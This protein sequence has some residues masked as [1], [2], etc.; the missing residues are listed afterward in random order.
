MKPIIVRQTVASHRARLLRSLSMGALLAGLAAPAQA[1]FLN[2]LRPGGGAA[3]ASSGVAGGAATAPTGEG[4]TLTASMISAR[5][6]SLRNAARVT[7]AVDFSARAQAAARSAAQAPQGMVPV[8]DGLNVRNGL[9]PATGVTR[10]SIAA[11]ATQAA[12][13]ANGLATW[14]GAAYPE[15]TAGS[16]GRV[17]VTI[18]Q[19][20]PTAILSWDSFNV[21]QRTSLIFDQKLGGIAQPSWV[22]VNRIVGQLNGANN[23]IRDPLAAPLPSQILGSIKADGIVVVLNQN[24][25]LFGPTSQINMRSMLASSYEIGSDRSATRNFETISDKDGASVI[26]AGGL[27]QPAPASI[28]DR[29]LSILRDGLMQALSLQRTLVRQQRILNGQPSIINGIETYTQSFSTG[30]Q[31]IG[32]ITVSAGATIETDGPGFIILAAPEVTNSG[33]LTAAEGQVALTGPISFKAS[34]GGADSETPNIRGLALTQTATV[35]VPGRINVVRNT[36][37]GLIEAPR[38]YVSLQ[39][40]AVLQDGVIAAT[41]SVSRNG[42]I[43]LEGVNVRLGSQSALVITPD[44]NGETVPQAPS[45]VAAFKTSQITIN[46][47]ASFSFPND[48]TNPIP[49]PTIAGATGTLEFAADS[50]LYAPNAAVSILGATVLVGDGAVV[51]VGGVKDLLLDASRNTIVLET[52]KRNELRD[53]PNYRESFLNG[54][55]VVLDPRRTG[56]RSDGVAWIGSPLIE[57]GSFLDQVGVTAAELMTRGGSVVLKATGTTAIGQNFSDPATVVIRPSARFDI[58]GGWVR[59]PGGTIQTSRLVNATGQLIDIAN[60]DVNESYVGL[61]S[62]IELTQQR[63]GKVD[64]FT[65]P[66]QVVF[67]EVSAFVEGRDAGAL[68]ISSNSLAMGGTIAAQ[69]FAGTVQR[70]LA[71]PGTRTASDTADTRRLQAIAAQLPAGGYLSV[72]ASPV[73]LGVIANP[74]IGGLSFEADGVPEFG[75]ATSLGIDAAGQVIAPVLGDSGVLGEALRRR[76]TIDPAMFN[77]AGLAQSRYRITGDILVPTG[78]ALMLQEGGTFSAQTAGRIDMLGSIVVPSGRIALDTAL[79]DGPLAGSFPSL[80]PLPG[81]IASAISAT[82]GSHDLVVSGT[83]STAGKWIND[84]L[85][86]R[87][88]GQAY[89]DGGSIDLRAASSLKAITGVTPF[90]FIASDPFSP[91]RSVTVANYDAVDVSGSILVNAGALLDVSSGG[92]V[93]TDGRVTLTARGGSVRL[94][95]NTQYYEQLVFRLGGER[96]IPVTGFSDNAAGDVFSPPAITARVAFAPGTIRGHGFGGGGTFD[97]TTPLLAFGS[98]DVAGG[99]RIPLDFIE[100]SGFGTVRLASSKT[101]IFQGGFADPVPGYS[102][103]AEVQTLNIKNDETLRLSQAMFPALLTSA[104]R[105]TLLALP[106]GSDLYAVVA[107]QVPADPFDRRAANF[108]LGGLTKLRVAAGGAIEGEAGARLTVGRLLQEGR[109]RLPGGEITQQT[110]YGRSVPNYSVAPG[111]QRFEVESGIRS[112]ARTGSGAPSLAD[113]LFPNADGTITAFFTTQIQDPDSLFFSVKGTNIRLATRTGAY[114]LGVLDG[115]QGLVLAPDSDTDLSGVALI[116][117]RAPIRSQADQTAIRTGRLVSGGTISNIANS[118]GA[119]SNFGS[120]EG[121]G[122]GYAY[123]ALPFEIA[124]GAKLD[125]RGVSDQFDVPSA[126]GGYL[127]VPVWSDSGRLFST[128]LAWNSDDVHAEAIVP[129]ARGAILTLTNPSL[130]QTTINASNSRVA[131]DRIEAAGFGTFEALGDFTTAGDAR[132]RLPEA[133][134]VRADPGIGP[135]VSRNPQVIRFD[136]TGDLEV[137][138]PFIAFRNDVQTRGF[139]GFFQT[140]PPGE[141]LANTVSLTADAV[142]FRGEL[143]VGSRIGAFNV[144]AHGD[145]R[146]IGVQNP[147]LTSG[148]TTLV[149]GR[150]IPST[151]IGELVAR[152]DVNFTAGQ[153]YPTTGTIYTIELVGANNT[154]T[155]GRSPGD[156]PEVPYSAGGQFSG[157][158]ANIVHGGVIRAPIG[159]ITLGASPGAPARNFFGGPTNTLALL[160]GSVTSTA[161]LDNAEVPLIIPYGETTDVTEYFFSP[162]NPNPLTAPPVAALRLGGA[163]VDAQLGSTIDTRGGGDLYAYEFVSGVFGSRDVLERINVDPYS[164]RSGLQYA[165][166]RQVYAILPSRREDALALYDPIYSRDYSGPTGVGGLYEH[167]AGRRVFLNTAPGVEAGWYTLLPAKYA[168]LPGALRLVEQSGGRALPDDV[169]STLIDGTI[170][171]TGYFGNGFGDNRESTLRAFALQTQETFSESSRIVVTRASDVFAARALRNGLTVPALPKDAGRLSFDVTGQLDIEGRL[172]TN[173]A[174]GGRGLQ[175]D[176]GGQVI[177]IVSVLSAQPRPG[178]LELTASLLTNLNAA[179]VL[180]GGTRID[181][182]DGTTSLIPSANSIGIR[183]DSSNPLLVGDAIFV[184]NGIVSNITA[185]DG[186]TITATGAA[187]TDQTG[188]FIIRGTNKFKANEFY[189]PG[190][191]LNFV[192]PD[193]GGQRNTLYE[194]IPGVIFNAQAA[195]EDLYVLNDDPQ[196][197]RG[198]LLQVTN[199]PNR[200]VRRVDVRE[201]VDTTGA[202][203]TVEAGVSLKGQTILF[204]ASSEAR[205]DIASQLDAPNLSIGAPTIAFTDIDTGTEGFIVNKGVEALLGRAQFAT[206]SA[207]QTLDFAAGDFKFND[208]RLNTA[209]LRAR[210]PGAAVTINAREL[211]LQNNGL[212]TGTCGGS[213]ALACGTGTL[214]INST[215]AR[216]GTGTVNTYGFGGGVTLSALGGIVYEGNGIFDVGDAAFAIATPFIVDRGRALPVGVAAVPPSL[217]LQTRGALSIVA[218]VGAAAAELPEGAGGAQL[219]LAAQSI[220]VDGSVLRATAG[221][222]TVRARTDIV[223]AGRAAFLTPGYAR[224]FGDADDFIDVSA[225][226]GQLGLIAETGR[227]DLGLQTLLS[228]G[229]GSGRAG[230][231]SL[232]APLGTI[233]LGQLD[234]LAPEGRAALTLD[235]AGS[236]SLTQLFGPQGQVYNGEVDIRT[237]I[238]DLALASGLTLTVDRLA[239]T[240]DGGRISIGGTIN[241]SGVNGGDI[242][243]FGAA[244]VVLED[245][246]Q[247]NAFATGYA[248]DDSRPARGGTVT[249]GTD[250]GGSIVVNRAAIIDLAARRPGNRLIGETRSDITYFTFAEGDVGGKLLVRAPLIERPGNDTLDVRVDSAASVRGASEVSIEAFKRFDLDAIARDP[251]FTGVSRD[252]A[253]TIV[254]DTRTGLNTATGSYASTGAVNFLGGVDAAGRGLSGTLPEFVQTFDVSGAFATLGGLDALD[255][256]SAKPGVELVAAGAVTL[257][258]N[259]NLGAGTVDTAQALASGAM[260]NSALLPIVGSLLVPGKT[261]YVVPGREGEITQ[262]YTRFAY[263]TRDGSPFG[264]AGVL[265]IRAG[266]DLAIKGTVTDGFFSFADYTAPEYLEIVQG[267]GTKAYEPVIRGDCN[268]QTVCFDVLNYKDAIKQLTAAGLPRR[269][270]RFQFN[271]GIGEQNIGSGLIAEFDSPYNAAPYSAIANSAAALGAHVG[272]IGDPFSG[273]QLFPRLSLNS[274]D[275]TVVA[276]T[277]YRF[278]A[279]ASQ[280]VDPAR[281]SVATAAALSVSGENAFTHRVASNTGGARVFAESGGIAL[282]IGIPAVILQDP[283]STESV[284]FDQIRVRPDGSGVDAFLGGS[285]LFF[286]L[287]NTPQI[288]LVD[289]RVTYLDFNRAT[290]LVSDLLSSRASVFF[291]GREA[292]L[293]GNPSSPDNVLTTLRNAVEFFAEISVDLSR[294]IAA[295]SRYAVPAS[296][297]LSFINAQDRSYNLG[298]SILDEYLSTLSPNVTAF[299][300]Q[301]MRYFQRSLVRTGASSIGLTASGDLNLRNYDPAKGESATYRAY[302]NPTIAFASDADPEFYTDSLAP[303]QLVGGTSVYSAGSLAKLEATTATYRNGAGDPQLLAVDPTQFTSGLLTTAEQQR[304]ISRRDS[305]IPT[306]QFPYFARDYFDRDGIYT[307]DL[308]FGRPL[309][310]NRFPGNYTR[311]GALRVSDTLSQIEFLRTGR[312]SRVILANVPINTPA[313]PFTFQQQSNN[314]GDIAINVGGSV[315]AES[316]EFQGERWR[317]RVSG[318]YLGANGT[319]DSLQFSSNIY[320]SPTLFSSGVAAFG[321]GGVRVRAGGAIHELGIAA[322]GA[323]Y[324]ANV[325][326]EGGA[327]ALIPEGGGVIDILSGGDVRGLEVQNQRGSIDIVSGGSLV[328]GERVL[329]RFAEIRADAVPLTTNAL[330]Y[331]PEITAQAFNS[332]KITTGA[333]RIEAV[334]TVKIENG[335]LDGQS[336]DFGR[337]TTLDVLANGSLLT[338]FGGASVNLTSITG[339]V[340]LLGDRD[341]RFE[342]TGRPLTFEPLFSRRN[343]RLVPSPFGQLNIFAGNTLNPASIYMRDDAPTAPAWA[344]TSRTTFLA[345]GTAALSG[346][347]FPSTSDA[348][349]RAT[350]NRDITHRADPDPVRIAVGGDLKNLTLRVPKEARIDAGRDIVDMIFFGQNLRT[351]DVT[352]IRAGRDII[353]TVEAL[354][355]PSRSTVRGNLFVING[356]G[357]LYLEAGR[358]AGPFLTSVSVSE[359]FEDLAGNTRVGEAKYGGGVYAIGNEWNRW[360]PTKSADISV[361][362]GLAPGGVF[363]GGDYNALRDSYLDPQARGAIDDLLFAQTTDALGNPITDRT[364]FLYEAPLIDWVRVNAAPDVVSLGFIPATLGYDDAYR[365]FASLP[366]LRQREFLLKTLYFNELAAP[367]I[368]GTPSYLKY[369]RGYRAINTLFSA[370][371]GFTR[372]NLEGGE[373]GAATSAATGNLDLR[374][375]AIQTTRN[376]D[377]IIM[378]P[379][380]SVLGGS[381]V[382]TELQPLRRNSTARAAYLGEYVQFLQPTNVLRV[383]T[384]L[385]GILTLRGGSIFGFTDNDIVLNQSRLF[386]QNSN[387]AFPAGNITLWSS[388]G[389]LNAGQGPKSSFNFPPIVYTIDPNGSFAID[390]VGG[391]T[392]AGIAAFSPNPLAV[393]VVYLIAPRGT[394][395]AGDAGVRVEGNLFVAAQSVANAD[396]FEVSGQAFGVPTVGQVDAGAQA[397]ANNSAAAFVAAIT[398]TDRERDRLSRITVVIGGY[399][400]G[401]DSCA[402]TGADRPASCPPLVDR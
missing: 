239:L 106:S 287:Q 221:S 48:F 86:A 173:P 235:T 134:M 327:K 104:S 171:T 225:P 199:G 164:T 15:Q 341:L 345:S 29:N 79:V 244:G 358:D 369:S 42:N 176:I 72:Q 263:R 112:I 57:A 6:A 111:T 252:A 186:A 285:G 17:A 226:G 22:A 37:E 142:E 266:G 151:L 373:A 246:A 77:A 374:L 43:L 339:D 140:P 351:S 395:D 88:E 65:N 8:G 361:Q 13:D 52:L 379:G 147:A 5:E 74:V 328:D 300:P 36:R 177:E 354:G 357:A 83:L 224:R 258:S 344:F 364:R 205:V 73:D 162:T 281:A 4:T 208:F 272:G 362:F 91:P 81:G 103:L 299:T 152:G 114:F 196:T 368:P 227:I 188:D 384:G 62:P 322:S 156:L 113:L 191:P 193:S 311:N 25:I 250:I 163:T 170:A 302:D 53:A 117:P 58:S 125:L 3:S 71:Q 2:A 200:L 212:A 320:L 35:D 360:L 39:S 129:E 178:V 31:P 68:T 330:T 55:T 298:F 181:N 203:L 149:G 132:L 312:R 387:N 257:A 47:N 334:G 124:A 150:A 12:R 204:D 120:I 352:R 335:P 356:P 160:P 133:F 202:K 271:P 277:A 141:F 217:S 56:V 398:P 365:V 314:G 241:T 100:T 26:G 323:Q 206:L 243:L 87:V 321:G 392:G 187:R 260:R 179:S 237:G 94:F 370:D 169:G 396:N 192:F 131:A 32:G 33:R 283:T 216:F 9:V 66:Q 89:V 93:A 391:V 238:D 70:T 121:I 269:F 383:P 308:F 69:S 380:G 20:A 161:A 348:Q 278:V 229:G 377:I 159:Q 325:A 331:T 46:A 146:F 10:E 174:L 256:F 288:A 332:A 295:D 201:R 304:R 297:R 11:L 223:A 262:D 19:S 301:T 254:L 353:G 219:K 273:A 60:A 247:L 359:Q 242:Q 324:T 232:I 182:P 388:N 167:N 265:S 184:V 234:A 107:P 92:Y 153:I 45:S 251:R 136:A 316:S 313:A 213:G 155:F 207:S 402:Q 303:Q 82:P 390:A 385:E 38:G 41:T 21:G 249:L 218:P 80:I 336:T 259:W 189:D 127:S 350:Y 108:T 309:E 110:D 255:G 329:S 389:D 274:G 375:A 78:V 109:I 105:N 279:G 378:G 90:T 268:V 118:I 7:A 393:P 349:R 386:S 61:L 319:P 267:G 122:L 139:A 165:D 347:I 248:E 98:D 401:A 76:I 198:A 143:T 270:V 382:R 96:P 400:S 44:D 340:T 342:G 366:I 291:A 49:V 23:G 175:F 276:S 290:P 138:A 305:D 236:F 310:Y 190:T 85:N 372:N 253:G 102:A 326:W 128:N 318:N 294:A 194:L 115:D 97:L 275:D 381:V 343:V 228:I 135:T 397:G 75:F 145:M 264:Q 214:S 333:I 123:R 296:R 54:A 363:A 84:R 154:L 172:R 16:D 197:G 99:T 215:S 367:S 24:G 50:T 289:D 222:L 27:R 1:Q 168:L 284:G 282:D 371:V 230:R 95:N 337:Y 376:S 18:A 209:G 240:A 148:Q 355:T 286:Q 14:Q 317:A 51:D 195:P 28:Q 233:V 292:R 166:G 338:S 137:A 40:N 211:T 130:A 101:R 293:R 261:T 210:D 63:W 158:A 346:A 157:Y 59:Y 126:A 185:F 116:N 64:A 307:N 280:S 394:V 306:F 30:T 180:V 34:T 67:R 315:L 399:I 231:L 144:T 220:S 245:G 119:P 183:N